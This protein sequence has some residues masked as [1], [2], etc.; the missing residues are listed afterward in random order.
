LQLAKSGRENA[1]RNPR[2]RHGV[3]RWPILGSGSWMLEA[4]IILQPRSTKYVEAAVIAGCWYSTL[5]SV[6]PGRTRAS[7]L[8]ALKSRLAAYGFGVTRRR[9]E[10]YTCH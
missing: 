2:Y 1:M 9:V 5:R 7:Y 3:W 8:A 4:A 6:L 10:K